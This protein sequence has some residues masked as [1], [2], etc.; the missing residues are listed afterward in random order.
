MIK[1]AAGVTP[2]AKIAAVVNS[3]RADFAGTPMSVTSAKHSHGTIEMS[4]ATTSCQG[5]GFISW[6]LCDE[7]E[8][9]RRQGGTTRLKC[10]TNR[11]AVC[12]VRKVIVR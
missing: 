6:P 10:Q 1:T 8:P 9:G 7:N 5:G 3:P 12:A 2:K 4:A 11:R